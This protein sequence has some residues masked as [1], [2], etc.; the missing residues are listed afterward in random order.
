M[1]DKGNS[2]TRSVMVI[3]KGPTK[4]STFEGKPFT[5]STHGEYCMNL[6]RG[7]RLEL[8]KSRFLKDNGVVH[9]LTCV[10]TP[11]QNEVTER[12]N[13]H[14][15]EVARVLLFQMFVPNDVIESL[16]VPTQDVQVQVQEVTEPTLVLEQVQ[17]FE[18]EIDA[19]NSFHHGDLEEEVY[20]EIPPGFYSHNE[21]NKVMMRLRN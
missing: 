6:Q 3:G 19:K 11:Q 20:L 1:L 21:K 7:G 8:L 4:R 12:K 16:L 2:N 5:K 9:E 13:R 17:L 18:P 10:N 14:L 15:L